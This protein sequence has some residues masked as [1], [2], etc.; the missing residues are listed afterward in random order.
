MARWLPGSLALLTLAGCATAAPTART[1]PPGGPP[2]AERP[3]PQA[4]P[5]PAEFQRA[6]ERGTRTATGEPGPRYWQNWARYQIRARVDPAAHRVEGTSAIVYHNRSPDALAQ[7]HVDLLLN[8]HAPGSPRNEPVEETG[9]V[10]V[11]AVRVQDQPLAAAGTGIGYSVVGTRMVVVPPQPVAP[12]DSV[13][14]AV[15]YAFSIPQRGAGARMGWDRDNLVFLAY[16]YPQMAVYDDVGGWHTDPFRGMAE[17]YMGFASY[18]VQI[19]APAGW[20]V[21]GTGRL[22]NAEDVLAPA[23]LAR[24]RAAERSDTVVRVLRAADVAG[25]TRAAPDGWLRWRFAADSVRDVAFSLTR[26]SLWDAARTPVGD[27]N[28]DGV[29]DYA[30]VDALYRAGATNWRNSVRHSQHSLAFFSRYLGFPY[31]WPHMT[32]VEG[33]GII[34]GGMEYPMMTLI[35]AYTG[36]PELALYEVTAHELAHMWLPMIVSTDERR[37][38]WMD[39]GTTT[40]NENLSLADLM[41]AARNV[42]ADEQ[43]AYVGFAR[44]GGEALMML[45]SDEHASGNAFVVASY[46]KP[47]VVLLALRG[48]LGDSVFD[49][50]LREFVRRWAYRHPQPWDL[51]NSFEAASGRD[52]DWFWW[53]WYYTTWRLDQAVASVRESTDGVRIELRDLGNVPMPVPLTIVRGG[54]TVRHT[55]PV[56]EWLRGAR[57]AVVQL[58]AGAPVTRVEIDAAR[59]FPDVDRANNVWA[60]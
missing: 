1:T 17:F 30:R 19:E 10:T 42:F 12:G 24:W 22:Q 51:W 39:E 23:V 28:G 58:P 2:T 47:A 9:G 18:D 13:R 16:W 15:D 3:L 55:V 53:S 46:P 27:R 14:L 43:A 20:V 21:A 40:F 7:L 45:P 31:P 38:S 41:P 57:T 50:G 49:R 52:L 60:H 59:A 34:G 48:V 37:Y 33:G 56:E 54:E 11:R 44:A 6:V 25:A 36:Q 4:L 26:E 35:G 29:V 8:L 32:A 5:V